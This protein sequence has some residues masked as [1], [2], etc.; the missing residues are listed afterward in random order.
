MELFSQRY[1]FKLVRTILQKDSIDDELRNRLWNALYRFYWENICK[2][3][4]ALQDSSF[5]GSIFSRESNFRKE[6]KHFIDLV[7]NFFK[8]LW[9][10]FFKR[11]IDEIL[12][13]IGYDY[14]GL[15]KDKISPWF[16]K[17][18]WYEVYD[19]L[20]FIINTF[21]DEQNN[22]E[23]IKYCN[24]ILEEEKS[25]YRFVDKKIVPITNDIELSEIEEALKVSEDKKLSNVYQHLKSAIELLADRKNP[26]YRNSIKKAISAVEAICCLIAGEKASLGKALSRIEEKISI[27][28]ALKNAFDKLYGYTSDADGIRHALLEE[29]NLGFEDAKFMLVACSAF[30][31]YLIQK[32]EKAEIKLN[33]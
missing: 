26:D 5:L 13:Y 12:K 23:F 11:P 7:D 21:P 29:T 3:V 33:F 8:K 25:A 28:P 1:G 15:I 19:F 9:D 20:E 18:N 10:G 4:E 6:D 24:Q 14:Y 17:C 22:K 16:F 2:K 30:I 27:H 31:N 32:A